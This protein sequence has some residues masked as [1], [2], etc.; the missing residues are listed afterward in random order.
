MSLYAVEG[1][2]LFEAFF[3]GLNDRGGVFELVVRWREILGNH[4]DIFRRIIFF[5]AFVCTRYEIQVKRTA[6]PIRMS[7]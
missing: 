1:G 6:I 3:S 7:D 5:W 4:D 2:A